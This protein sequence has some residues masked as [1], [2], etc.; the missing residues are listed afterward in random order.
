V[1]RIQHWVFAVSL[2]ILGACAGTGRA[3]SQASEQLELFPDYP[4]IFSQLAHEHQVEGIKRH[5]SQ[6]PGEIESDRVRILQELQNPGIHSPKKHTRLMPPKGYPGYSD[7]RITVSHPYFE[8]GQLTLPGD[9]IAEWSNF[10]KRAK[11]KIVVNVFE[12]DLKEVADVLIEKRKQGL[13]VRVGIDDDSID[14]P[15]N[16]RHRVPLAKAKGD[17]TTA[18][19]LR[20][21]GVDVYPVDSVGLNHQKMAAIDWDTPEN[22]WVLF[23][24]GNLTRSCLDRDGDLAGLGPER[25]GTS[26]PNANHVIWMRSF[27][28]ANLVNYELSKTLSH[29]SPLRG[30][31]YPSSGSYQVTGPGVDPNTLE[32]Y[33]SPSLVISFSPGGGIRNINQNIVADLI[34]NSEGPL[35]LVQFAFASPEVGNA[36]MYR[37]RREFD[38]QKKFDF[39]GV[40]DTPFAMQ[41][42]SQFLRISSLRKTVLA[43]K[44]YWFD[45]DT[46]SDF[47]TNFSAAERSQLREAVF[48]APKEYAS[49]KKKIDG[50]GYEWNA[51]LHHKIL[52]SG[53]FAILG[54]SFNLS[55]SA[56]RNNEQILIFKD[57]YLVDAV[58]GI[59]R[60]LSEKSKVTVYQEAQRR[61]E[62][63]KKREDS[64]NN[65]LPEGDLKD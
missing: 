49:F 21:G 2:A 17:R 6:H 20:A 54:T 3:P 44:R 55:A 33:P 7:L 13:E 51:K 41:K 53:E 15:L 64:D 11:K 50:K 52:S 28:L 19:Y 16:D 9:L 14:K 31:E 18:D 35:R 4:K 30:A 57:P 5:T 61:N 62:V 60:Y 34:E 25:P 65:E 22:S 46:E 63:S 37:A 56:E 45:E 48:I 36:V 32:A 42:W 29:D 10:F 47:Y 24:S 23:S 26:V 58:D 59:A 39:I 1:K 12:F 27:V 8:Q 38:R 40:G 43:K